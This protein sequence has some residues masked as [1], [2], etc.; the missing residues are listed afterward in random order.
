[1][2]SNVYSIRSVQGSSL[3]DLFFAKQAQHMLGR[4]P[5]LCSTVF[6]VPSYC[7]CFSFRVFVFVGAAARE[8][9]SFDLKISSGSLGSASRDIGIYPLRANQWADSARIPLPSLEV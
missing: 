6:V 3:F 7:V 1:M 9:L 8:L 2:P 5:S 4:N